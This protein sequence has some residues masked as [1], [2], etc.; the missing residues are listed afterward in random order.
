M[1]LAD[2][3]KTWRGWLNASFAN[4]VSFFALSLT[5][6]VFL[7]VGTGSYVAL[8]VQIKASSSSLACMMLWRR[9]IPATWA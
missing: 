7:G 5:V 9:K 1:R 6:G 3:H 2:L 8:S 4:Q